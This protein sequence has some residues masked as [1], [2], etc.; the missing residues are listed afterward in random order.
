MCQMNYAE[1]MEKDGVFGEVAERPGPR[2]H[3]MA[4]LRRRGYPQ[5][6]PLGGLGQAVSYL[7]EEEAEAGDRQ[8]EGAQLEKCSRACTTR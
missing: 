5:F 8:G 4:S 6:V 3:R 7:N 1:A 2:L